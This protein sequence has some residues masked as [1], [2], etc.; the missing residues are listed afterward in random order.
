LMTNADW[1]KPY[2][3][4]V[5]DPDQLL[6]IELI[7]IFERY[8]TEIQKERLN[9]LAPETIKLPDGSRIELEY[10]SNGAPPILEI[11]L[12]DVLAWDKHPHVDGGDMTIELHLLT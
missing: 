2:L 5:E 10:Q 11:R 1:L 9:K 7:P 6:E 12:Q 4:E 3:E 8:L